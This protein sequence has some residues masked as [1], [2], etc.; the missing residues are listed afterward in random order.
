[1][2]M[3]QIRYYLAVSETLN[4]TRAAEQCNV[5][6]PSLTR[7]IKKLEAELGGDL[8][9]RERRQT[10]M[11]DLGRMMHPL[12]RQS[13]E[14][15]LAAK[16]QA[17]SVKQEG[18]G[19]IRMALSQSTDIDLVKLALNKL[20]AAYSNVELS[21]RRGAM[22]E[23]QE[24]LRVGDIEL[25]I[26]DQIDEPW[27]R[28]DN[29]SLFAENFCLFVSKQ[30]RLAKRDNI[31]FGEL[32]QET[33]IKRPYCELWPQCQALLNDSQVATNHY[34]EVSSDRDAVR[35]VEAG[36][37]VAILP[38]STRGNAEIRKISLTHKIERVLQ[39]YTVAGRQR[40]PV[41]AGLMNQLRSADWT[42]YETAAGVS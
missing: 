38:F 42:R 10:H 6:Q 41:L 31:E 26:G 2:E 39:M 30:H 18:T 1:M 32:S 40:S 25:V 22:D 34:V 35:M 3:H 15:A 21:C 9:R 14:S 8:F 17:E 27:E 11:T 4:F 13:Y 28:L 36:F 24:A 16:T 7:A 20:R 37:G 19:A 33:L 5:A 12:L 29:W 23:I